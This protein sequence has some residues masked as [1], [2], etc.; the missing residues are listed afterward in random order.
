MSDDKTEVTTEVTTE[1]TTEAN[2]VDSSS[3]TKDEKE[4]VRKVL[5]NTIHTAEKNLS[6]NKK[7]ISLASKLN[8]NAWK[9]AQLLVEIRHPGESYAYNW[10]MCDKFC[11]IYRELEA[12]S[13]ES[14]ETLQKNLDYYNEL[15]ESFA[16]IDKK[17]IFQLTEFL[18]NVRE[19]HE[20]ARKNLKTTQD[21]IEYWQ[22]DLE[23]IQKDYKKNQIKLL[24]KQIAE[25]K[26][27]LPL[28]EKKLNKLL[29][30]DSV[31]T[32]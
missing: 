30:K 32:K 9:L 24:K 29:E 25:Y 3:L 13:K 18:R 22:K 17:S 5:K 28:A 10:V 1:A 8:N 2:K 15:R 11:K 6:F 20:L 23:K 27:K 14:H 31:Q 19:S 21:K 4:L 16:D 12:N 7:L 26:R